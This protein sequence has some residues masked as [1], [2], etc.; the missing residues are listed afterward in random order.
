MT[1]YGT[2]RAPVA[3]GGLQLLL[4]ERFGLTVRQSDVARALAEGLTYDEVAER[5]G[6]SPHTVHTHVKNIHERT[7]IRSTRR[8]LARV[9]A[10][11]LGWDR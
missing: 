5:L 1:D 9:N 8:L 10:V 2:M 7:G 4:L 6:I 3:D 11:R